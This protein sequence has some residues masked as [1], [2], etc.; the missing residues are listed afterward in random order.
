MAHL[1]QSE[2]TTSLSRPSIR[3]KDGR[4]RVGSKARRP[5]I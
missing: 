4:R 2:S 5:G 3:A 1:G